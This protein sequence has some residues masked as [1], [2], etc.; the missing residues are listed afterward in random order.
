MKTILSIIICTHNPR[1]EYLDKVLTSLK[2]QTLPQSQW[3]LILI[4]NSSEKIL[5][6][7]IDLSW[8]SFS[9]HVREEKLGLTNA[10]LRA[11]QE[12]NA[13]I[14]VFVDDDNILDRNYLKNTIEILERNPNL[15]AIGGKSLPEFEI[16]PESWFSALG[17]PLGLRDLG[18]EVKVA[19]W[20]QETS[21]NYPAFAPI[22]AG[23]VI[24]KPAAQIYAQRI[25]NNNVRLA[26]GRTGKQLTSGEDNDIVL[27]LLDAG[28]GVGYFP[29]LE[30]IHLI[31]A[32]RLT[33][34]YLARLNR[35]SSR[36]W[37]QVLD[38][39]GIRL[40]KKIPRWTVF[41]RQIKAFFCYQPWT[42]PAAY[43]GW[44][45]A[46]GKLEGQADLL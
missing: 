26:L 46:C 15:G 20:D 11:F 18:H 4:D 16:Q 36:S 37:V 8:H 24:R 44:Q 39:H 41:L 9:R 17:V 22:G 14:L 6:S 27:T 21:R 40:W 10:R 28:Y 7:E 23:L 33:Q 29:E 3:E 30:L 2:S 45:G 38:V 42:S 13:D 35:A 32:R 25:A 1:S 31:P 12:A 5:A 34:K 19:Y 43:I